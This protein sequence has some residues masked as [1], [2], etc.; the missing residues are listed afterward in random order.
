MN[1]SRNQ[2]SSIGFSLGSLGSSFGTGL[3]SFGLGSSG[4]SRTGPGGYRSSSNPYSSSYNS[5]FLNGRGSGSGSS[6]YNVLAGGSSNG[7]SASK[8][9][10]YTSPNPR[11]NSV[12]A[13]HNNT[14]RNVTN[15]SLSRPRYQGSKTD[16][17][18]VQASTSQ[19]P[20]SDRTPTQSGN[21]TA[22]LRSKSS[23]VL[24]NVL[25]RFRDPRSISREASSASR[26][27]S[28][29][30][31]RR[32]S[33]IEGSKSLYAGERENSLTK[34]RYQ[35]RTSVG[36]ESYTPSSRLGSIGPSGEESNKSSAPLP[37]PR[38]RKINFHSS[39]SNISSP[40]YNSSSHYNDAGTSVY[41]RSTLTRS[42][43]FHGLSNGSSIPQTTPK[44]EVRA[45]SKPPRNRTL[46]SGVSQLDLERA[47][48]TFSSSNQDLRSNLY[49][50]S[51]HLETGA[52]GLVS[53]P[54]SRA[55]SI[56]RSGLD[57]GYNSQLSSRRESL[58]NVP[59]G[60]ESDVS[61]VDYKKLWEDSQAENV[62]LRLELNS[63]RSDLITTRQRLAAILQE[64]SSRNSPEVEAKQKKNMEKR[65]VEMEGELKELQKLKTENEK[66]K[67]ENRSLSQ[68]VSNMTAST[69]KENS[70]SSQ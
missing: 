8:G 23:D 16:S 36:R 62:Q 15:S 7:N 37:P 48:R 40:T 54:L 47:R 64:G 68:V 34:E 52:D 29:I 55:R 51:S 35:E 41:P 21:L 13:S 58:G 63:I 2:R 18:L 30:G 3:S 19:Q 25:D 31:D 4:Y 50:S 49:S 65:L 32:Q 12:S 45:L 44:S 26:E 33:I 6:A 38:F 1:R 60:H 9:K 56:S 59:T 22:S 11:Y 57:L 39:T 61:D 20:I 69:N 53:S 24:N 17:D 10:D 67:T 46:T 28:V 42:Q 66:L 14:S 70:P 27:V 43:S 5:G